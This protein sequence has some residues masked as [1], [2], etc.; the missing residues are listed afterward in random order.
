MCGTEFEKSSPINRNIKYYEKCNQ[1]FRSF[2]AGD[3][4]GNLIHFMQR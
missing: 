2:Y 4:H 3:V 1:N